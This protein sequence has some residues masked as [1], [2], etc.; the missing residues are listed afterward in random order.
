M[1]DLQREFHFMREALLVSKSLLDVNEVPIGCIFVLGDEIIASGFNQTNISLCGIRH[2]ELVAIESIFE[3]F[4]KTMTNDEIIDQIFANCVVYVGVEPCIMCASTLR[5]LKIKKV[6]FG[7][8]NERFGGNGT[9]AACNKGFPSSSLQEFPREYMSYPGI[10]QKEAIL[11]LRR[12]YVQQNVKAPNPKTKKNRNLVE[13][14]FPLIEF[15]KYL[16]KQE[17]IGFYG[18]DQLDVFEGRKEDIQ[19]PVSIEI[20]LKRRK[21]DTTVQ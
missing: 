9:V 21:I 3:K 20:D 4:S 16:T 1:V 12:F 2:A 17:F 5:Q 10:C 8:A 18:E 13:D 14:E 19:E 7:C 6:V 15:D 11:L